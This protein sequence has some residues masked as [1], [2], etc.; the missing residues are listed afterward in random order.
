M[1]SFFHVYN[2]LCMCALFTFMNTFKIEGSKLNIP[3][4]FKIKYSITQNVL[5]LFHLNGANSN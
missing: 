5:K 3:E 4:G 1:N 2:Q